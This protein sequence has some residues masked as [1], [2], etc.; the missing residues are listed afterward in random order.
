[1]YSMLLHRIVIIKIKEDVL[2]IGINTSCIS[3]TMLGTRL[4]LMQT[5]CKEDRLAFLL[6][7]SAGTVTNN[8]KVN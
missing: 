7:T 4:A 3:F 1:M 6:A 2:F 8:N 5:C